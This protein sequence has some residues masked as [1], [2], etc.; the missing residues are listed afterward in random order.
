MET[1]ENKWEK[2]NAKTSMEGSM[3]NNKQ[4]CAEEGSTKGSSKYLRKYF[5]KKER[6]SGISCTH[7]SMEGKIVSNT[8]NPPMIGLGSAKESIL[9]GQKSVQK[10]KR[11]GESVEWNDEMR[12]IQK[13][14]AV[15]VQEEMQVKEVWKQLCGSMGI[16]AKGSTEG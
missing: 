14:A 12:E 13:A 10:G 2:G 3:C 4:I 11:M 7:K 16:H 1:E 8:N 5:W 9:N 15:V 6:K